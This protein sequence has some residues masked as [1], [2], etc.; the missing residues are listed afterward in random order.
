[1]VNL[2][3]LAVTETVIGG[4]GMGDRERIKQNLEEWSLVW[5]EYST[6]E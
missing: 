6:N 3:P 1:M 4:V 2:V 5:V